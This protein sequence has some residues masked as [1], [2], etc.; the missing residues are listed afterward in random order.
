MTLE[1]GGG[2]WEENV[3]QVKAEND[4]LRDA[5]GGTYMASIQDSETQES[6]TGEE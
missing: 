1:R 3:A 5:G 6:N 4:K 2:D